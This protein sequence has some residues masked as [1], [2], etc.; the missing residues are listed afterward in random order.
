MVAIEVKVHKKC[1]TDYTKVLKQRPSSSSSSYQQYL[2][3]L[4][5]FVL[6]V[7]SKIMTEGKLFSLQNLLTCFIKTV[8]KVE[9][10]DISNFQSSRLKSRLKSKYPP[11]QRKGELVFS[12]KSLFEKKCRIFFRL[13]ANVSFTNFNITGFS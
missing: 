10:L 2:F 5:N 1:V 7:D 11:D 13:F 12:S 3:H 6:F 9:S 4:K 8:S